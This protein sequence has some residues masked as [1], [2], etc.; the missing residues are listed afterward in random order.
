MS[1]DKEENHLIE[2]RRK[3]LAELRKADLAFPNDFKRCLNQMKEIENDVEQI[4]SSA[5]RYSGQNNHEYDKSGKSIQVATGWNL[6][7]GDNSQIVCINWSNKLEIDGHVDELNLTI[8]TKEYSDFV[9]F[10]AFN[11]SYLLY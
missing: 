11:S 1:Q 10:K 7:S 6:Q 3:K 8:G 2:E 9:Q 4:F 5:K